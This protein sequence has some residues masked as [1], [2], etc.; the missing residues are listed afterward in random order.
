MK[1]EDKLDH[2]FCFALFWNDTSLFNTKLS[3]RN[4]H[5]GFI[6]SME[7]LLDNSP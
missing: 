1:Q 2:F 6:L 7:R 3:L 4:I 5:V